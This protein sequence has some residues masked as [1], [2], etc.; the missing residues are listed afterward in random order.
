VQA[1]KARGEIVAMTGDGVNDAPALR[2][3]H[4]GIAMGKRGTD[5]AREAASLVL[6]DDDFSS[7][8]AGIRMGRRIHDNLQKAM[9]YVIAMHVVIGG[10]SLVPVLVGW[11]LL[12]LPVHIV[13]LE[14]IVDPACSLAF[15]A[16]AAEPDVMARPPRP[17]SERLVNRYTLLQAG[18]QGAGILGLAL[19]VFAVALGRA[20]GEVDA[21]ALAFTTSVLG[22]LALIW[23]NRSRERSLIGELTVKNS[24]LWLVTVAALLM[25]GFS[26]Y[27]PLL[28]NLFA[29]SFL[30]PTDL[31]VCAGMAVLSIAW[32]ELLKLRNKAPISSVD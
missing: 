10:L 5:V 22:N 25:L 8:V 14:L 3:A 23:S 2:A 24:L 21:R 13:F 16:E 1:F 30:H 18:L 29:F 28:R 6:L 27:V 9:S 19:A 12:L 20:Q 7:I 32:L 11:P 17:A 15:E 4:I 26:L 31:A